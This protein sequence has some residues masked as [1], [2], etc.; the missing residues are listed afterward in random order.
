[1]AS[2]VVRIDPDAEDKVLVHRRSRSDGVDF[3]EILARHQQPFDES[4]VI[5][6][7]EPPGTPLLEHYSLNLTSK[8]ALEDIAGHLWKLLAQDQPAGDLR[9]VAEV[10]ADPLAFG[11]DRVLLDV[12]ARP[13]LEELPWELVRCDGIPLFTDP[14]CPW[15]RGHQLDHPRWS[16][17]ADLEARWPLRVLVLVGSEPEDDAVKAEAEL[18]AIEELLASVR[19]R[20][21]RRGNVALKVIFLTTRDDAPD[22]LVIAELTEFRP[23]IV[24]FIGHGFL[25]PGGRPML[26]IG[27]PDDPDRRRATWGPDALRGLFRRRAPRL[28]VL[29]ACRSAQSRDAGKP[30]ITRACLQAG[31]AAVIGMQ[32]PIDGA[33]A[34]RFGRTLYDALIDGTPVDVAVADA[35]NAVLRDSSHDHDRD[36][37]AARLT[38]AVPPDQ[39]VRLAPAPVGNESVVRECPTLLRTRYFLDRYE[40]G[41]DTWRSLDASARGA[42]PPAR[43]APAGQDR[44]LVLIH[45]EDGVGK[46]D[47][48]KVVLER[49][50]LRGD[51][52][53][54]VDLA[55]KDATVT[56]N[57]LR[58]IRDIRPGPDA[59][60]FRALLEAP[61][62][63]GTFDRFTGHLLALAHP[64]YRGE[65]LPAEIPGKTP[66][67]DARARLGD[68]GRARLDELTETFRHCLHGYTQTSGHQRMVIA[69]DHLPREWNRHIFRKELL[70]LLF[71]W[72]DT[73]RGNQDLDLDIRF[74]VVLAREQYRD[75]T[76]DEYENL[77]VP[78]FEPREWRR[79]ATILKNRLSRRIT[80]DRARKEFERKADRGIE[81]FAMDDAVKAESFAKML[82]WCEKEGGDPWRD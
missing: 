60:G 49:C 1:M 22:D 46:T 53:V 58:A 3:G 34:V 4:L 45:G 25:E 27:D 37:S 14:A 62:P 26:A 24:H 61:W 68:H 20:K 19:A 71:G 15:S 65:P 54:Y 40:V 28:L 82:Q 32:A 18:E 51:K 64:D 67:E 72:Y 59:D 12:T 7:E 56:E 55:D 31:V 77:E 73:A 74:L 2:A 23:D 66:A 5:A 30:D 69:V 76:R 17:D 50:A 8:T 9:S 81:F 80:G 41:W 10:L 36:W 38:L 78:A 47:L 70:A 52:V 63:E 39:V 48:V 6:G 13:W 16:P 75:Y 44:R 21:T 29:E 42:G 57:V 35:R 11:C 79:C 33:A 43:P